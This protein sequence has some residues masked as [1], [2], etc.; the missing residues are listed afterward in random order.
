MLI[1]YI[2][3]CHQQSLFAWNVNILKTGREDKDIFLMLFSLYWGFW[4]CFC[5]WTRDS[6]FQ[7]N[8]FP[9][10]S[11]MLDNYAYSYFKIMFIKEYCL[12]VNLH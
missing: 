12:L 2:T 7:E 1:L 9:G 6:I 8:L 3:L 11:F 4:R 10:G 5:T